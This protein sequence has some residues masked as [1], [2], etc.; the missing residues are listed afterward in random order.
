VDKTDINILY[1][2]IFYVTL[3]L[4]NYT[5]G[6]SDLLKSANSYSNFITRQ[7]EGMC[8]AHRWFFTER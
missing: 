5:W 6:I 2:D 3:L 7:H 1:S 4:P 8:Y